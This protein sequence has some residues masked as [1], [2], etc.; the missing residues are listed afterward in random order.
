MAISLRIMVARPL[1]LI[2]VCAPAGLTPVIKTVWTVTR[3]AAATSGD[4]GDR[5]V[6]TRA[7][8]LR[9]GASLRADTVNP[10]RVRTPRKSTISAAF[11]ALMCLRTTRAASSRFVFGNVN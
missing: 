6:Q 1:A 9:A 10:H 8:T 4:G 5:V 2:L 11:A 7:K 3:Q